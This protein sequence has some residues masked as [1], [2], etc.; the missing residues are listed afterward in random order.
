MKRTL[1]SVVLAILV[2]SALPV[3]GEENPVAA[4]VNKKPISEAQ[5]VAKMEPIIEREIQLSFE[6]AKAQVEQEVM[7]R[8]VEA[9]WQDWIKAERRKTS[10]R[11]KNKDLW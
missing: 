3:R 4:W 10:I 8:K 9:A 1:Y 7:R 11:I 5:V 2:C 6:Q